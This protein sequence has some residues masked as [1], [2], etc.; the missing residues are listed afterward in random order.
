MMTMNVCIVMFVKFPCGV[1]D[2][3]TIEI[4]QAI[5]IYAYVVKHYFFF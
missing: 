5:E 1:F 4:V 3:A 2:E